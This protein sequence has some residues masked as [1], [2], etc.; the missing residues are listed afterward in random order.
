MPSSELKLLQLDPNALNRR[1]SEVKVR[2]LSPL[3]NRPMEKQQHAQKK[4]R[5]DMQQENQPGE[6]VAPYLLLNTAELMHTFP[7]PMQQT[8]PEKSVPREVLHLLEHSPPH[9]PSACGSACPCPPLPTFAWNNNDFSSNPSKRMTRRG[10]STT[11]SVEL[12]ALREAVAHQ[13]TQLQEA[14]AII[15]QQGKELRD[16]DGE[17]EALKERLTGVDHPGAL[18][19][20]LIPADELQ[21]LMGKMDGKDPAVVG[22]R[23]KVVEPGTTT[24][25]RQI[26]VF[27]LLLEKVTALLTKHT[28]NDSSDLWKLLFQNSHWQK[29]LRECVSADA[30]AGKVRVLKPLFQGL[31]N[32]KKLSAQSTYYSRLFRQLLSLLADPQSNLTCKDIW[33]DWATT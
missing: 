4:P 21:E 32:A 15:K 25:K 3:R 2:S 24:A 13:R 19:A 8:T 22:A 27:S 12:G 17:F 30:E 23:A 16:K 11:P 18:L 33:L 10:T 31:K 28:P 29:V 20:A 6:P 9:K 5:I 14:K 1:S 7:V 26:R